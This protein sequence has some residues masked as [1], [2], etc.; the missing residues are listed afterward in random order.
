[1]TECNPNGTTKPDCV[2]A[3]YSTI[4][5]NFGEVVEKFES[6]WELNTQV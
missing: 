2:Q 1:M 4:F 5:F 6:V 3:L